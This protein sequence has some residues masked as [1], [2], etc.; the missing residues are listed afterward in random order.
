MARTEVQHGS[1]CACGQAADRDEC[2][3]T[4]GA[5]ACEEKTEADETDKTDQRLRQRDDNFRNRGRAGRLN[6]GGQCGAVKQGGEYPERNGLAT[7]HEGFALA[8]Q[9]NEAADQSGSNEPAE[10]QARIR[11]RTAPDLSGEEPDVERR[12][13][14][15]HEEES[16]TN[17]RSQSSA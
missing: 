8:F 14:G 16:A 17:H 9:N 10:N 5:E 12:Q 7:P 15:T 13:G 2:R 3:T 1:R 11:Q 4:T 6:P